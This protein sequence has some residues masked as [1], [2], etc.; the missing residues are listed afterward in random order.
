MGPNVVN[1]RPAK[2]AMYFSL[3]ERQTNPLSC[4]QV[5]KKMGRRLLAVR[6]ALRS[7]F[8]S[9]ERTLRCAFFFNLE[10]GRLSN[11]DARCWGLDFK[12]CRFP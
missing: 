3:P 5:G 11:F 10:T 4:L 2:F 8:Q 9:P 12:N 6:P 7:D 1:Q